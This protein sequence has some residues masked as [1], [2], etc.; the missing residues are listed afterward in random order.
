[1]RIITFFLIGAA[2]LFGL[3]A[4]SNAYDGQWRNPDW[5]GGGDWH[6]S[7]R[8]RIRIDRERIERG[9]ERGSLTRHE[10]RRLEAE[11]DGILDRIDW[12]R[13][14]GHLNERERE[15]IHRELDRLDQDITREK[16]DSE[17]RGDDRR[18]DNTLRFELKL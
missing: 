17:R 8:E 3:P 14:D 16:R 6:G 15:A 11:L 4:A 7:I 13:R 12:M 2:L 1:M 10:A 9:I 18:E 5:H